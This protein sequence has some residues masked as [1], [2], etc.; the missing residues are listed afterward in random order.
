MASSALTMTM[1]EERSYP[2]VYPPPTIE[3]VKKKRVKVWRPK[4]KFRF[5]DLPSEI[6]DK[7]Y[8]TFMLVP[9][10][11]DLSPDNRKAIAPR[12][13]ILQICRQ[14][15][16]E[17]YPVFYG[18]N[19]FRIFP[20]HDQCFHTKKVLLTRL[21]KRYRSAITSLELRLG[22]GWSKPPKSWNTGPQLGLAD[23]TSVRQLKIFIEVDPSHDIFKGYRIDD[24]FYTLFCGNLC[25]G[26]FEQMPSIETVDFEAY[27]FVKK[28]ST[29][30]QDLVDSAE[31]EHKRV[32]YTGSWGRSL[33]EEDVS[34]NAAIAMLRV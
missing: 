17:A 6:R 19:T 26:I 28:D 14:I 30:V 12:L 24:R 1:T 22:P 9:Y 4:G 15:N 13:Q 11:V 8:E 29:L 16:N 3:P 33:E 32:T 25:E 18:R 20:T 21:C 2:L 34:L 7:I 31:A 5:L 10:T 23:C 27:S